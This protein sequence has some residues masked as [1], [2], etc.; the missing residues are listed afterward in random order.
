MSQPTPAY[1]KLPGLRTCQACALGYHHQCTR[2]TTLGTSQPV[3]GVRVDACGCLCPQARAH[4]DRQV[5][6]QKA[7]PPDDRAI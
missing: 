3:D 6:H 2:S 4:R 1:G 7:L 5:K